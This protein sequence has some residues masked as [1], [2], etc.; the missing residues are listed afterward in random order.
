[1][2]TPTQDQIDDVLNKCAEQADE[3]GSRWPGMSYEEGVAEA[4]RWM[5][6]DGPN[7]MEDD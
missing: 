5:Q 7:P 1:M 6:G 4:I 3:G 2:T